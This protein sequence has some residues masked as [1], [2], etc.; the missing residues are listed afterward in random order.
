MIELPQLLQLNMCQ[1]S[2][3]VSRELSVLFTD[4][5][6]VL[7]KFPSVEELTSKLIEDVRSIFSHYGFVLQKRIPK[8]F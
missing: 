3:I 1:N 7:D 6:F 8:I 2:V 5:N 4:F